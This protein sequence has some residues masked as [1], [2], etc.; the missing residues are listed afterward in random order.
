MGENSKKRVG[1]KSK[2]W[3]GDP[4][5]TFGLLQ[6]GVHDQQSVHIPRLGLVQGLAL[7]LVKGLDLGLVLTDLFIFIN[8]FLVCF[9]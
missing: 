9:F 2:R 6:Q 4:Q 3:R 8:W 7:G 1:G 5:G